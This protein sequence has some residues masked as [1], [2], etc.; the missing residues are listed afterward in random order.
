MK[1]KKDLYRRED[2]TWKT[3]SYK[4]RTHID[5]FIPEW[6]LGKLSMKINFSYC[7]DN[8][9]DFD[10]LIMRSLKMKSK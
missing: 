7:E 5:H 8:D 3:D 1:V 2:G 6:V 4:L 10:I 9:P